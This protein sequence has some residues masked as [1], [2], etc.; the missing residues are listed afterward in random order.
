MKKRCLSGLMLALF[1]FCGGAAQAFESPL[2]TDTPEYATLRKM[3]ERYQL[4]AEKFGC[5]KF[6]WA[7]F[8]AGG[9][10]ADLEYVPE[11]TAKMDDWKRLMTVTVYSLS[12]KAETDRALM[13][14]ILSGVMGQYEKAQANIIKAEYFHTDNGEPGLFVRYDVG[15]G[16]ARE[17]NAGVF[18]RASATSA[19]FIQIQSRGQELADADAEQ[20]R[21]LIRSKK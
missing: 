2:K 9:K 11:E 13:T 12:G 7:T 5:A 8:V 19:A 14:G 3:G 1:L 6:A 18:M 4:M 17:H 16:D 21:A 10:I 15:A 20:V